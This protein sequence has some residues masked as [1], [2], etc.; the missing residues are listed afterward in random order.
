MRTRTIRQAILA[1]V[2][3]TSLALG[4][5]QAAAQTQQQDQSRQQEQTG[6]QTEQQAGTWDRQ[7]EQ[8]FGLGRG[9]GRQ[10][11]TQAEWREHQQKMRTMTA[12]ERE[13]YRLETHAR[14][15]ERAKERGIMLP[16]TPMGPRS[17]AP[18]TGMG[19]GPGAGPGGGPGGGPGAGPGKR[20]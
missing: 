9:L 16:D 1:G 12:Q 20:P 13:Q 11:M 5:T 15:Q 7:A 2:A 4:V 18:G 17:G 8:T 14:M 6:Q 10:L 3:I 19:P